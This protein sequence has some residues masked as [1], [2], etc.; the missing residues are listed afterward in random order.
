MNPFE[1]AKGFVLLLLLITVLIVVLAMLGRR[2][3]R[4]RHQSIVE[5]HPPA[6]RY[7]DDPAALTASLQ[8]VIVRL[9]EQEKELQRLLNAEK[10]RAE[11]ALRLSERI[12][13]TMPSGLL[14]IDST[15]RITSCNPAA[16]AILGVGNVHLRH[17][18][19]ILGP[20]SPLAKRL[21]QCLRDGRTYQR[22]EFDQPIAN[23][24]TRHLGVTISPILREDNSLSGATCLL[25]DLTELVAMQRQVHLKENL[26]ALGE[27]TA[28]IAHEFKNA[29][30]AIS[31][32]AQMIQEDASEPDVIRQAGKILEETKTWAQAVTEF[33]EY[34]RPPQIG[35]QPLPLRDMI[36]ACWQEVKHLAPE[37]RFEIAGEWQNVPADAFLLRRAILNLLRNAAEA[38]APKGS[39]GHISVHGQA[40]PLGGADAQ[41]MAFRDNGPGI[42]PEALSRIFFPFFTTKEKGTG[43]GLTVVQKIVAQHHGTIE[44]HSQLNEGTEFIVA[45]PLQQPARHTA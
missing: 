7:R 17:Y 13:R 26:A 15:G 41:W 38:L 28:G 22:E 16:Q 42:A 9:R 18:R 2:L 43:L 37:S 10:Q 33:L 44:V 5:E 39:S 3:L 19:E 34:A 20:D 27:L 25:S 6:V 12:A 35:P 32:Y 29:L 45:L 23:R 24:Q 1:I 31:A 14:L 8:D 21:A 30:G 36:E 40:K 11:D 4:G